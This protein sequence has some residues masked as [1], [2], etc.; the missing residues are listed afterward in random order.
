MCRFYFKVPGPAEFANP[1]PVT[2]HKTLENEMKYGCG[3]RNAY[4]TQNIDVRKKVEDKRMKKL[5]C[6]GNPLKEE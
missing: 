6:Y 5:I 3:K 1:P 4:S 2:K